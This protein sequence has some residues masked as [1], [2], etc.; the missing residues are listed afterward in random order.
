M[1]EQLDPIQLMKTINELEY[2]INALATVE[3][4]APFLEDLRFPAVTGLRNPATAKP[5]YDYTNIGFLFDPDTA[6]A[7][8]IIAQMPHDWVAGGSIYPHVHW[9]PTTTNAGSV[10]WTMAYKWTNEGDADAD[11]VYYPTATQAA[12]GTAYVHQRANLTAI[13]GAGKTSSS[14]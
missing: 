8:Y 10:V 4:A 1:S 7:I 3:I 5:D 13:D 12:C 6:E 11:T 2:K 14:I 9:M